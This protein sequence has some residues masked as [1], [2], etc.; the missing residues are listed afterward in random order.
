VPPLKQYNLYLNGVR[1]WSDNAWP[2]YSMIDTVSRCA[3]ISSLPWSF[4]NQNG[5]HLSY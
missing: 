3:A 1:V 4:E 5:D 2:P